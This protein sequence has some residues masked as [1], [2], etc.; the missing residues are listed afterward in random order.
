VDGPGGIGRLP[1]MDTL[2]ASWG[3]AVILTFPSSYDASRGVSDGTI[4]VDDMGPDEHYVI[5]TADSHAGGS[6]QQYREFLDP[7]YRHDFDAWRAK[8]KNPF[9]D[10]KETDLRV[11]NWDGELR[12]SQ[13]NRDGIVGE[14]IFPNTVPPFFPSFVLFAQPPTPE[15]Y[16]H[17]HAGIQAHN[18]WMADFVAQK[19]EARAGIGQIFLNDLDDAIADVVWCRENGLRGGVLVGSVPPTCSWLKPLYDPHYDPLWRVCEELGVPVNAHSGTG[20]PDYP[21]A[22]AMPMVHM[23]EMIFYSQRPLVYLVLAGVFE[24]FPNLTF[25]LT[26]AGCSWVPGLLQQLD[27]L[28]AQLRTGASGEM[29]FEGEMVPPRSAT[30]YFEHSC[31][32][33]VSQP[34]P[35]DVAAALG[36]VGLDRVMW[37]SDYPHEEGT[38]P[39]TREHLRQVMSHLEPEQIQQFVA[40]NAAEVYGFDLEA[41]RPAA[42]RFGPTVAEIAQPLTE[43]PENPNE[44]L[45]RSARELAMAS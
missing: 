42:D 38:Y 26:E 16:E 33:G 22:P 9:K 17:R 14:V 41:L 28:M 13:L 24:R 43:L 18:R 44:A 20:G 2:G 23:A 12:D 30:E 39:F 34:R 5:I 45:R 4:E 25:V 32:V 21:R 27:G 19:P 6:H 11:R 40:G 35:A 8:Y 3:W 37:G 31:R 36:P 15:E 7:K 10:L 29:R 1:G